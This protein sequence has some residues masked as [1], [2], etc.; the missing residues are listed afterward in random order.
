MRRLLVTL[1]FDSEDGPDEYYAIVNVEPD[2]NGST[3]LNQFQFESAVQ[4]IMKYYEIESGTGPAVVTV[5]ESIPEFTVQ[6][7]AVQNEPNQVKTARLIS[8]AVNDFIS[9]VLVSYESTSTEYRPLF[10]SLHIPVFEMNRE[11]TRILDQNM[12]A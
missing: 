3:F 2:S 8:S 10:L 6:E 1:E 12:E 9:M 11:F 7:P 5:R 4:D